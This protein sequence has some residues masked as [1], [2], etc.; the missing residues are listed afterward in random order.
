MSGKGSKRRPCCVS[1]K[2]EGLRWD[3]AFGKISKKEYD[4]AVKK[5]EKK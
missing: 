2:E 5:L 4:E 1:R 3:L